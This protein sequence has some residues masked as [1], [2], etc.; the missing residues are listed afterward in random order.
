M[1]LAHATL[2]DNRRA[3]RES[4]Q[5]IKINVLKMQLEQLEQEKIRKELEVLDIPGHFITLEER[6]DYLKLF[7]RRGGQ[8]TAA[9]RDDM[10]A[11]RLT[12]YSGSDIDYFNNIVWQKGREK[13]TLLN[14]SLKSIYHLLK[15]ID[16]RL[17]K[18][19]DK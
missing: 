1:E 19:E 9:N 8:T 7:G 3:V 16:A 15:N 4:S 2:Y 6:M 10:E 13:T 14:E 11:Y 12:Y 17:Q 18:L 5:D